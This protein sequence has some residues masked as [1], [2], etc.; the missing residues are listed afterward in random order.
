MAKEG[1]MTAFRSL[2]VFYL[3]LAVFLR[4]ATGVAMVTVVELDGI[5]MGSDELW[6]KERS[7][8]GWIAYC[9]G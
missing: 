7:N 4:R 2:P 8:E 9:W 3:S 6:M 5:G 1:W